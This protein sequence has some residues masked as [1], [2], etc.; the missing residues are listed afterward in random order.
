MCSKKL[1]QACLTKEALAAWQTFTAALVAALPSE[2]AA[3]AAVKFIL[4]GLVRY[5]LSRRTER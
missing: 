3:P 4:D 1:N 2:P 5:A